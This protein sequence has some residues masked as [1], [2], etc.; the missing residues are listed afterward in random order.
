MDSRWVDHRKGE[1]LRV[2]ARRASSSLSFLDR[3]AHD[4]GVLPCISHGVGHHR[5]VSHAGRSDRHVLHESQSQ[6]RDS[7]LLDTQRNRGH[8]AAP[9]DRNGLRC[10]RDP[11]PVP[12]P[13]QA[14]R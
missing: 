1:E 5:D 8:A 11:G 10:R 9:I 2:T 13:P 4:K 6:H 7:R 12:E 14:S 3:E